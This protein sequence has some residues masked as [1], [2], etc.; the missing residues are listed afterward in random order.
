LVRQLVG[1]IGTPGET[2]LDSAKGDKPMLAAIL[3]TGTELTRGELVNTNATWIA[4]E[5]TLL[6]ASVTAI[7]TVDDDPQR[8]AGAFQRLAAGHDIVVCTGGLGPTTDDVTAGALALAAGVELE[9]HE[10]S[11]LAI[12]ARLAHLGRP[13]TAS[14]AKQA[15]VPIGCTVLPNHFGTAPGFSLK[16]NRATVYCLPGVPSEMKAMFA[17]SVV[18]EILKSRGNYVVQVVIRTL[19]MAESAVNDAL[20]GVEAKYG[21]TLG[22]RVHFPELAVKVV[23][24]GAS[25]SRASDVAQKAAGAVCELLGDAVVFGRDSANLPSILCQILRDQGLRLGIAESCTGGLVSALITEQPGVSDVFAGSIVAYSNDVKR[26]LLGVAPELIDEYG[27]VSEP[28]AL[29]MAE[30]VRRAIQCD[31]G[32]AI[33]GIAGPTG[34]TADKPLGTVHIAVSGPNILRH[35]HRVLRWD[36]PRVQRLAAF[37]ALNWIRRLLFDPNAEPT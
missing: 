30:G 14:N 20:S 16:L 36:R 19:G 32:L 35:H 28:T 24:A 34:A 12:E 23:A 13:V 8:I 18:P 2:G 37:L 25:Q 4:S 6:D 29:A 22:Y 11:L 7:D 27:A 15:D 26:E 33:T 10:P 1:H 3:S 5:L 31:M 9:T 17:S 21:V